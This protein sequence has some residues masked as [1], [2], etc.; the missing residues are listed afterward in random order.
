[1]QAHSPSLAYEREQI[2]RATS[3]VAYLFNGRFDKHRVEC[4]SLAEAQA[5]ADRLNRTKATNT[6]QAIVYAITP[7]QWSIQVTPENAP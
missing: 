7:E 5:E 1:M 6:R 3:F 2:A 4:A